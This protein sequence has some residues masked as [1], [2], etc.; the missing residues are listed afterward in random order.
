M[1]DVSVSISPT[2]SELQRHGF[3]MGAEPLVALDLADTVMTA[4]RPETDLLGRPEEVAI[5]WSLQAGRLPDAPTPDLT[6]VRRLRTAVRDLLDSHLEG[7]APRATSVED[8]NAIAASVPTS[9]RLVSGVEP[10]SEL[11][12]HTEQGGNAA[13][14]AIARE[15]IDL[16]TSPDRLARLRRCANPTCSMLFIAETTRRQWCTANICGNRMRVARHYHRTRQQ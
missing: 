12:W 9:P 2:L 8:I 5:W 11:R 1:Y 15:T 6:A 7:R 14:A 4:T 3:P 13:L 10:H 16:L